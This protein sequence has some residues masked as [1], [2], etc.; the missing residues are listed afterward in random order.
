MNGFVLFLLTGFTACLCTESRRRYECSDVADTVNLNIQ[1]FSLHQN[2]GILVRVASDDLPFMFTCDDF[3]AVSD[4]TQVRVLP[5]LSMPNSCIIFAP[6][7]RS[8]CVKYSHSMSNELG[9]NVLYTS[10]L[11]E[12][13][14]EDRTGRPL[15]LRFTRS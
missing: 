5:L 8:V 7:A 6:D 11:L 3:S 15:S 12:I 13:P 9:R 14:L 1:S 2:R 10:E 4:G